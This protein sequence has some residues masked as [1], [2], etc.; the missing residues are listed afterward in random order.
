T[1]SWPR[2]LNAKGIQSGRNGTRAGGA[3]V[4]AFVFRSDGAR[5]HVRMSDS[6]LSAL[7]WGRFG[8][9]DAAYGSGGVPGEAAAF[10]G[11]VGAPEAGSIFAAATTGKCGV[12]APVACLG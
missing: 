9:P 6:P 11:A 2:D 8:W 5:S 10:D 12:A 1:A 4:S 3:G 7:G